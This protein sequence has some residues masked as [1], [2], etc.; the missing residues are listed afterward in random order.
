VPSRSIPGWRKPTAQGWTKTLFAIDLASA[1]QDFLR[2]V[3]LAP[4][5]APAHGYYANLLAALGRFDEALSQ[6][7]QARRLDPLWLIMP[8]IVCLIHICARRFNEAER[9]MRDLMDLDAR[10]DGTYWF[11]S[12]ALAGQGRIDEAVSVLERGVSLVFRAPFFLALLGLWYARAGRRKDAEGTLSELLE[13][14]RTPPVWLAILCGG[15]GDLDRA[16]SY[17]EQAIDQHNDQVCFMGVDH[18]FD[19]L[20]HDPRFPVLMARIGL[21]ARLRS[22][23][24]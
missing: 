13:G 11:L 20:R 17:L 8:F 2:A 21:P 14:G 5:F 24:L 9:Q 22:E 7:D 10:L 15:L 12:S 6:A 16:F 18:R 1:E 4:S 23:A 3:D 19:E